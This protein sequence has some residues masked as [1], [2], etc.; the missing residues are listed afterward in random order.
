MDIEVILVFRYYQNRTNRK[1][2]KLEKRDFISRSQI[3]NLNEEKMRK[4]I[5]IKNTNE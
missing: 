2:N 3:N 5:F 1:F 4:G